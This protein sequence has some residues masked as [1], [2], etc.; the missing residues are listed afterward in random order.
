MREKEDLN[1]TFKFLAW[2]SSVFTEDISFDSDEGIEGS[3]GMRRLKS[4]F[5]TI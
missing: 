2:A 5:C 3:F 1:R 4:L